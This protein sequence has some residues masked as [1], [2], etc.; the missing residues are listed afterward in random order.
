MYTHTVKSYFTELHTDGLYKSHWCCGHNGNRNQEYSSGYKNI[1]RAQTIP[2]LSLPTVKGIPI[3]VQLLEYTDGQ[4]ALPLLLRQ[5]VIVSLIF[6]LNLWGH[7]YLPL[8][9]SSHYVLLFSSWKCYLQ[10]NPPLLLVLEALQVSTNWH[11][12]PWALWN[13]PKYLYTF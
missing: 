3:G 1:L 5:K 13:R 7:S 8:S 12:L 4:D 2:L 6:T 11:E 9:Y 10:G